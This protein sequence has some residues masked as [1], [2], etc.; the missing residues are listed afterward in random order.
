MIKC[1][2]NNIKASQYQVILGA[3]YYPRTADTEATITV[4]INVQGLPEEPKKPVW[5]KP[6]P[7]STADDH[8]IDLLETSKAGDVILILSATDEDTEAAGLSFNMD[9]SV[10]YTI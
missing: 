2:K 1:E 10:S 8:V 9:K 4:T 3:Y 5:I 6:N 7:D